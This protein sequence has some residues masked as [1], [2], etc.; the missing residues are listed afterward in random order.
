MIQ[1]FIISITFVFITGT[2]DL[3]TLYLSWQLMLLMIMSYFVPQ[4]TANSH[5]YHKITAICTTTS[6]L[7]WS[8]VCEIQM[9]M[10]TEF[11]ML[12]QLY[13]VED[14]GSTFEVTWIVPASLINDLLNGIDGGGG[15]GGG[16]GGVHSYHNNGNDYHNNGCHGNDDGGGANGGGANGGG[17]NGGG[18]HGG[19]ANGGGGG[20]HNVSNDS[21]KVN[22]PQL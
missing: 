10:I 6:R 8:R 3:N 17:A 18:A 14:Y 1:Y 5:N 20:D 15:G 12:L 4:R 2:A 11:K 7:T 21:N 13:S 9:Y 16:G 19:G 22:Y